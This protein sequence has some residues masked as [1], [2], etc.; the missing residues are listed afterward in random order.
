M[1]RLEAFEKVIRPLVENL[2]FIYVGLQLLPLKRSVLLR[3]YIDR[4]GGITIDEIAKASRQINA[5][6]SVEDLIQGAY[7]LEVSSPGLDR[8][9]FTLEQWQAE[10]GKLVSVR[11]V[12]PIEG[13]RNF[14]GRLQR[15]EGEEI[16]I[17]LE[18]GEIRLSFGDIDEARLVPEW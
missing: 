18:S 16:F 13:R 9:L 1:Q 3:L 4:P 8:L 10:I 17:L 2:G 12:M 5:T 6:L 11:T 14:K 15:V 7:T